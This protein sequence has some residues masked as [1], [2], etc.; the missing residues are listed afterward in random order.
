MRHLPTLF[1]VL[2]PMGCSHNPQP[3]ET[4]QS[5]N[6]VINFLAKYVNTQAGVFQRLRQYDQNFAPNRGAQTWA[7]VA[8]DYARVQAW[9]YDCR[10]EPAE[11][12]FSVR[13]TAKRSPSERLSF[14]VDETRV[15]RMAIGQAG[16]SSPA[17]RLNPYETQLLQGGQ[18]LQGH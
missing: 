12:S 17:L 2:A 1:L 18:N 8:E 9:E 10:I 15:I 7:S 14:Y 3:S 11:T 4:S 13:C 16:P 5:A 6:A